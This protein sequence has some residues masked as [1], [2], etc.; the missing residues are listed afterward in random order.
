MCEQRPS[1]AFQQQ[2]EMSLAM[3]Q[4]ILIHLLLKKPNQAA[5]NPQETKFIRQNIFILQ[6]LRMISAHMTTHWPITFHVSAQLGNTGNPIQKIQMCHSLITSVQGGSISHAYIHNECCVIVTLGTTQNCPP[7][8]C[9][10]SEAH[11][12]SHQIPSDPWG[13]LPEH[14]LSRVIVLTICSM[15]RNILS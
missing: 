5:C 8:H 12:R 7:N 4:T 6:K 10:I 9:G 14:I 2:H 11:N 1:N 15:A 3:N 13:W